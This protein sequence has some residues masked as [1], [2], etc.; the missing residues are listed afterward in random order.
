[1]VAVGLW[2]TVIQAVNL[3]NR[4]AVIKLPL[5]LILVKINKKTQIESKAMKSQGNPWPQK[6][7]S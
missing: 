7:H 5:N 1:M 4:G 2:R 6:F 3:L